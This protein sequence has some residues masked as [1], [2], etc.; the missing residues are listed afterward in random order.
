MK[1]LTIAAIGALSLFALSLSAQEKPGDWQKE[2]AGVPWGST[3]AELRAA[4]PKVTCDTRL[5]AETEQR[6][7]PGI[8]CTFPPTTGSLRLGRK[9]WVVGGQMSKAMVSFEQ[10]EYKAIRQLLIEKYGPPTQTGSYSVV[11]EGPTVFATLDGQGPV[12][13]VTLT[14]RL[15]AE[16]ETKAA[17]AKNQKTKDMF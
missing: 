7:D 6:P 17:A 8:A 13:T 10:G 3:L 15:F 12:P 9:V 11:W 5:K 1:R 14:T 2:F 4:Q 16:H